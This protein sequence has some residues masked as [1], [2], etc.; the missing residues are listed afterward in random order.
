MS[1][2]MLSAVGTPSIDTTVEPERRLQ[3]ARDRADEPTN[4][5]SR[6]QK[7]SQTNGALRPQYQTDTHSQASGPR[8]GSSWPT[9]T[10]TRPTPAGIWIARPSTACLG[11]SRRGVIDVVV[12]YKID[13]LTRSLTDFVK[14]SRC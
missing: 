2:Q 7:T 9:T 12:V 14:M 11:I 13:Q 8:A 4:G 5:P 1:S 6:S 3:D 10:T